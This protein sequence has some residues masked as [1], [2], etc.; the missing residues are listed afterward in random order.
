MNFLSPFRWIEVI[1]L[2]FVLYWLVSAFRRKRTKKRESILQ[3]LLYMIPPIAAYFLVAR[4]EFRHGWLAARF[5][6]D[7]PA[8][9]WLGV[10]IAAAGVGFALWARWHLGSNWS[11][12]VTLK[13]DHE[14]IR[15][16]PYRFIRHPIYTGI[17][18]GLLGTF[19]EDGEMRS[20]VA[21]AMVWL[22]FYI[23]ARREESFLSQ[24]FG[25]GFIEHQRQTGMFLPKFPA[26]IARFAPILLLLLRRHE[27]V[28]VRQSPFPPARSA[29]S[30]N[31][32]TPSSSSRAL[33]FWK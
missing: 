16:G 27:S 7:G 29:H 30:H 6:P 21:L 25:H 20:L 12:V 3:R 23:K 33:A 14:L 13:E 32:K 19:L 28:C 15:S 2:I 26:K 1:W 8:V 4:P 17:L 22:S 11:G 31:E 24:E 5:V 9:R 10:A 18:I